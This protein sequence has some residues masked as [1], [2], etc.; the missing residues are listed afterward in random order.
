MSTTGKIMVAVEEGGQWLVLNVH[1][2]VTPDG[3]R[4]DAV[5]GWT[6]DAVSEHGDRVTTT[7]E[8]LVSALEPGSP[9]CPYDGELCVLAYC[10]A[11]RE[12]RCSP[13]SRRESLLSW[14]QSAGRS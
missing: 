2:F 6:G 11:R 4:W 8:I 9:R 14:Q 5:N 13:G 12:N 3:K 10:R 7:D 1:S